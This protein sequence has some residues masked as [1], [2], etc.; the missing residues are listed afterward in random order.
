MSETC[1]RSE[2]APVNFVRV[3]VIPAGDKNGW[4]AISLQCLEHLYQNLEYRLSSLHKMFTHSKVQMNAKFWHKNA[5][6]CCCKSFVALS[7]VC[8]MVY[9]RWTQNMAWQVIN[10]FLWCCLFM[11]V[12]CF[13][14]VWKCLQSSKC[15]KSWLTDARWTVQ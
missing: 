11:L 10:S 13:S 1:R 7:V 4:M 8:G 3:V 5:R 12:P 2:L 6:C 14:H 9:D 15:R